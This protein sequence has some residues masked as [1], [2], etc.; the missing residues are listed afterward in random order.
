MGEPSTKRRRVRKGT[1]SCWECRRRKIKCLFNSE[2]D[3]I[4][5]GCL[6][7]QSTCISQ[8]YVPEHAAP[9]PDKRLVQR[10]GRLEELM[11]KLVEK[12]TPA[13]STATA[14]IPSPSESDAPPTY[15]RFTQQASDVFDSS[16]ADNAHQITSSLNPSETP[17]TSLH[18]PSI[19]PQTTRYSSRH[20]K[21]DHIAPQLHALFPSQ[22]SLYALSQQSPGARFVLSVFYSQQDQIEGKPEPLSALAQIP[23]IAS[24]PTILAKRLLQLAICLQQMPPFLDGSTLRLEKTPAETMEEWVA[25]TSRLV[26]SDDDLVGSLEGLECLVLQSLY[27]S[28]AGQLRKSWLT[29]RR[30]L[31]MAQLMGIDRKSTKSIGSCDPSFDPKRLPSPA[32]LWFRI[33][34]NDRYLSLILGLSVGSRDNS[35]ASDD[36]IASDAPADRL[37]KVYAVISGK[38]GD[39]NDLTG[40]EAYVLTQ[41]IDLDLEKAFEM[42]ESIW[43]RPPD[44]NMCCNAGDASGDGM[45]AVKLQ[46]RH[47]TLLIMLHLPY[48]LRDRG[49]KRYEY[50]RATCMQASREVLVRFLQYRGCFMTAISGRHVDYSALVAAMSLLLGYLGWRW[51]GYETQREQDRALA[52]KVQDKMQEMAAV[53]NDR[54]CLEAAETIRQLLPIVQRPSGSSRE[55]RNVH[56]NIPFLGT[57]NINPGPTPPESGA[58]SVLPSSATTPNGHMAGDGT[59]TSDLPFS[60]SLDPSCLVG[61]TAVSGDLAANCLVETPDHAN[62]DWP[63]FTAGPEDWALQGVDTTYWSMLNSSIG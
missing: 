17:L 14:P 22:Q 44:T 41:S 48:L 27:Q 53:N 42:K 12:S 18:C 30:A 28:D 8:E 63:C 36:S 60:F 37:G 25:V 56:L 43:W 23:D 55:E 40:S 15:A 10:L 46:I 57:V 20:V 32:V 9:T 29:C 19:V 31:N 49:Q 50:N 26:T 3:E 58:A 33:N 1:R 62:A 34:C 5:V 54:L 4:C 7:R 51:P 47:H 59:L 39:R 2:D 38:I 6:Q 35:F 21:C 45:V 16:V 24:H 13:A 11:E 61:Q 52:D